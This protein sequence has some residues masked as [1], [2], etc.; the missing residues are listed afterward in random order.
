M[1]TCEVCTR[2]F[3]RKDALTRHLRTIHE[4]SVRG[5]IPH[6]INIKRPA[7]TFDDNITTAKR[8]V[9]MENF[10]EFDLMPKK[11]PLTLINEAIG[12]DE[13][14]HGRKLYNETVVQL[15]HPFTCKYYYVIITKAL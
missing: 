7:V 4:N 6:I 8:N 14:Y 1:Y 13:K 9:A 10:S 3:S 5:V 11:T 15:K 2:T 12:T